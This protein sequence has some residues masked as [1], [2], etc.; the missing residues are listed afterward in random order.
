M[1]FSDLTLLDFTEFV[2]IM[3]LTC[4]FLILLWTL[5]DTE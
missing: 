3:S 4:G 5:G 2:T 1:N